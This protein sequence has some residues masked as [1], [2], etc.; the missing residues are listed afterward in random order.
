MNAYAKWCLVAVTVC[1][2]FLTPVD[3]RAFPDEPYSL[4]E[5]PDGAHDKHVHLWTDVGLVI[6]G[7]VG[8]DIFALSPVVGTRFGFTDHWILE[9]QWGFSIASFKPDNGGSD[10]TF[11]PG[12][13]FVSINYQT[14]KNQFSYR[15][16]VGTTVPVAFLPDDFNDRNTASAAYT[17]AA[18]ARGNWDFWM[19][20]PHSIS[21][22]VPMKLE[23][24]K[25]SGFM[26]GA[27]LDVGLMVAI[28]DKN[29]ETNGIIQVAT[30]LGY[31]VNDWLRVGG[32][33]QLVVI[34]KLRPPGLDSRTQLSVE[35][36]LRF[37]NANRFF[38]ARLLI[39]I[40]NP[41]GFAFD[42]NG[43]WGLR[44]GAGTAF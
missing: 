38:A 30:H 42:K 26:W 34:P 20:D 17:H 16:G 6:G 39:N 14:N 13:P 7:I 43:I 15:I 33:F 41:H 10:K 1:G 29:D 36:Y 22:I 2:M 9:A 4:D 5:T 23:R 11:R 25:P 31:Q 8:G 28:N 18:S 3:A 24:R 44:F 27:E 12:S 32:R 21:L 40:D 35:P 37:G 19:W